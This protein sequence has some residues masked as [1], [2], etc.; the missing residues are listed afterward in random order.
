MVRHHDGG[1]F[2]LHCFFTRLS[3]V[4]HWR[5]HSRERIYDVGMTG[6]LILRA[7]SSISGI[8]NSA[9][10]LKK[11]VKEFGW[12]ALC[13][14]LWMSIRMSCTFLLQYIYLAHFFYAWSCSLDRRAPC[15]LT[16]YEPKVHAARHWF[17]RRSNLLLL[18]TIVDTAVKGAYQQQYLFTFVLFD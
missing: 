2:A 8:T 14:E 16:G 5:Y 18:D 13:Y 10:S 3:L 1:P 17:L 15:A 11:S 6:M 9:V 4:I 12:R 7:K